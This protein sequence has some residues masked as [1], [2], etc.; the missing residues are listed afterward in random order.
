MTGP[1][2]LSVVTL[3]CGKRNGTWPSPSSGG[4]HYSATKASCPNSNSIA[5]KRMML[6]ASLTYYTILNIPR[7]EDHPLRLPH[8]CTLEGHSQSLTSVAFCT[9]GKSVVSGSHD[10]TVRLRARRCRRSRATLAL[11]TRSPSLLAA[12]CCSM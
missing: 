7:S 8:L 11:S 4:Q 9:D 6:V 12:W 10:E 5:L 1:S 3:S 2:W